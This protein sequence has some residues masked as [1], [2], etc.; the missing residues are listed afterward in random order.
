MYCCDNVR[1]SAKLAKLEKQV[2]NPKLWDNPTLAH[3][4]L[5]QRSQLGSLSE[6]LN[7]LQEGAS[8]WGELYGSCVVVHD[9]YTPMLNCPQI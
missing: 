9:V 5:Q 7:Q 8:Q 1:T 4:L 6:E 2:E 3:Q